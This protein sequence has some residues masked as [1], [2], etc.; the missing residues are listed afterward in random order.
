[1]VTGFNHSGFVVQDLDV[2]VAFYR[3]TLGLTVVREADSIA[4]EGGDHTGFPGA[5]RRLVFVGKPEGEHL[6]ELVHY[7]HP[8]SP[9]GHLRRNQLGAGHVCFNVDLPRPSSK[10]VLRR[11]SLQGPEVE[12]VTPGICNVSRTAN[13]VRDIKRGKRHIRL[14]R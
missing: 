14:L 7:R 11:P 10:G 2:M 9:E 13:S 5:R 1:M 4:P 8:P 6:L 3:D 12:F